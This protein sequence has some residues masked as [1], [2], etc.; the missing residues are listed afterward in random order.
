M[1]RSQEGHADQAG[2]AGLSELRS[3]VVSVSALPNDPR[4]ISGTG[5]AQGHA[6]RCP[7][8]NCFVRRQT[9]GDYLADLIAPLTSR[10]N[11]GASP[12]FKASGSQFAKHRPAS[13]CLARGNAA[14]RLDR[15]SR[16]RPKSHSVPPA[17]HVNPWIAPTDAGI[18]N[19]TMLI[20]G[21]PLDGRFRAVTAARVSRSR[22]D[23]CDKK[24]VIMALQFLTEIR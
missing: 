16:G 7:D 4:G 12:S 6:L 23:H 20:L 8:P 2:R 13:R 11:A 10:D 24:L 21:R 1:A 19:A 9:Y 14:H 5:G 22:V 15:H 17:G 18:N 3:G